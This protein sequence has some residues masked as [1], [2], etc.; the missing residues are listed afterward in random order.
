[1]PNG[2]GGAGSCDA[3]FFQS[4][5]G[6]GFVAIDADSVAT[7]YAASVRTAIDMQHL[8]GDLRGFRQIHDRIHDVFHAR[9][10]PHRLQTSRGYPSR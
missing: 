8:P 4:L 1:M 7:I 3:K 10:L 2:S 5:L 9:N 6:A